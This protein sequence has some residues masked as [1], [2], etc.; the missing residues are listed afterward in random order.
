[1]PT[2][3]PMVNSQHK[4]LRRKI[5]LRDNTGLLKL[6]AI[7]VVII[8]CL[9]F[10][11]MIIRNNRVIYHQGCPP[12]F[13][14]R[15]LKY[16]RT[17]ITQLPEYERLFPNYLY[18]FDYTKSLV[19]FDPNDEW[20]NIAYHDPN[21]PVRWCVT[22]GL[23]KHY[24][25][26]M[27]IDIVFAKIDPETEEIISPGSHEEPVFSLWEVTS[28]SITPR[29]VL[30]GQ[31]YAFPNSKEVKTLTSDEWNKLVKADGDFSV[32]GI[33]LK[34]DDPMPNFELAFRN[35]Q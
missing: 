32:L 29:F 23:H 33:Q 4:W 25:L 5:W 34:K 3:V 10:I 30:F 7:V 17:T 21:S 22:A 27:K 28:V 2:I 14:T 35:N 8:L 20:D 15:L 26:I 19:I 6:P 13:N 18:Y 1:M 24:L 16:R 31:R 11:P 12:E 9:T